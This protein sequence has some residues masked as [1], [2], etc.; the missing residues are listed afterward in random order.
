MTISHSSIA[1]AQEPRLDLPQPEHGCSNASGEWQFEG[2]SVPQGGS[3]PRILGTGTISAEMVGDFLVV[4]RWSGSL[5][6]TDYEAFQSLGYDIEEK[7]YIGQWFD[8]YDL[9]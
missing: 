7:K 9:A 3:D 1:S 5:D 2:Q 4:S 8:G 6:G